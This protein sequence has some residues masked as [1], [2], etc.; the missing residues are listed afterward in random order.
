MTD[1]ANGIDHFEIGS[2]AARFS[3]LTVTDA[4]ADVRISFANVVIVVADVA[5]TVIGASDFIFV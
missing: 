2:G 1:F 5:H 4:G 3:D